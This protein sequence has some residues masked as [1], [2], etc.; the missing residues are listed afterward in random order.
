LYA[1]Q[2]LNGIQGIDRVLAVL[3]GDCMVESTKLSK[4]HQGEAVFPWFHSKTWPEGELLTAS[5]SSARS[6]D[7]VTNSLHP[8]EDVSCKLA[9]LSSRDKRSLRT[10]FTPGMCLITSKKR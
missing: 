8:F 7:G 4:E 6:E 2:S 10:F 3:L 9:G 1:T 5:L